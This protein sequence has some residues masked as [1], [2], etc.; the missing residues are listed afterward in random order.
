MDSL[1]AEVRVGS[2]LP[3]SSSSSSCG[4]SGYVSVPR[5]DATER[6]AFTYVSPD[7]GSTVHVPALDEPEKAA[8][9]YLKAQNNIVTVEH[10]HVL[11]DICDETIKGTRWKCLVC[12]DYDICSGCRGKVCFTLLL[13]QFVSINTLGSKDFK[14]HYLPPIR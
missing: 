6:A 4:S 2:T 3:P 11:C 7:T 12:E 13:P 5:S 10:S 8:F 1:R 9:T 14:S